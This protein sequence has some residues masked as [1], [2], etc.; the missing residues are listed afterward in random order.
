MK[1][2]SRRLLKNIVIIIFLLFIIFFIFF[3][4]VLP[5]FNVKIINNENTKNY[6]H[7]SDEIF[8]RQTLNNCGPYSV[9]AVINILHGIN[10]DPEI[11][12]QETKWRIR[13]NMTFPQGVIDLLHKYNIKTKEYSMKLYSDTEKILWLKN[14]IDNKNAVI[15]LLKVDNIQHYFTI[16]GYD[17][18]GFMIYDSLQEKQKED[19]RKTI[20]DREDCAGNRYYTYE[21]LIGLWNNGG[22]KIFFKNWAVVCY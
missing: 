11:L 21:K 6:L 22:Y 2:S 10:I 5:S 20:I 12:A 7:M 17:E 4:R 13:K 18:E 16:I 9:M 14:K 8:Y 15:L 3:S 19:P 1:Q